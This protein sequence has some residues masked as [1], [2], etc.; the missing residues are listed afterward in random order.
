VKKKVKTAA[1]KV[2]IACAIALWKTRRPCSFN[3]KDH[4]ENPA[5]NATGSESPLFYAIGRLLQERK[6][7]KAR[8]RKAK[9]K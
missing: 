4:L 9:K 3:E 2:V 1:E 5:V 8:R 6:D 7:E